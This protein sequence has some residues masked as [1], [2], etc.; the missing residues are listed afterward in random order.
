MSY[1]VLESPE[2]LVEPNLRRTFW[3]LPTAVLLHTTEAQGATEHGHVLKILGFSMIF[4]DFH[5]FPRIFM[6]F[7]SNFHG[8]SIFS[9]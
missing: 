4:H 1:H 5:G 2:W 7:P 8:F 3:H 6:D 9:P